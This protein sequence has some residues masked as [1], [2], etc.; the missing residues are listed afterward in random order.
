VVFSFN[1][2]IVPFKRST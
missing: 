2:Q 1:E